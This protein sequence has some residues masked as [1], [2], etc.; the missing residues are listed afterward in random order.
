MGKVNTYY[1]TF[2]TDG[3]QPYKGG[4]VKIYA[5]DRQQACEA[6]RREYPDKINGLLNCAGIYDEHYFE[7]ICNVQKRQLRSLLSRCCI[8]I[9][10]RC[11]YGYGK[12]SE[13]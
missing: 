2:G 9:K 12:V 10:M 1:F 3:T 8:C 7:K 6:F 11:K 5:A 13:H 4:W